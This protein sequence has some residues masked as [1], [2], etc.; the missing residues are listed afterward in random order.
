MDKS[1]DKILFLTSFCCMACDGEIAAEE[2]ELLKTFSDNEHLFDYI[3]LKEEFDNCLIILKQLGN[4][5]I[6][7]YFQAIESVKFDEEEKIYILDV[8][9]KTILADNK[10]EY[11]EI[12]FIRSL[13]K[14][15]NI[16]KDVVL[17]KVPNIEDYWLEND[18]AD[19]EG[20]FNYFD[21][22]QVSADNMKIGI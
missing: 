10:V 6:K 18:L 14:S 3:N 8:G 19:K 9:V 7:S 15:L 5:F 17:Q 22:L 12:K 13:F 1:F 20:D 21:Q 16:D 4:D 2:V 11:S